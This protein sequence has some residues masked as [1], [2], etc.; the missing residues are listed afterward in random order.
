MILD[1]ITPALIGALT[2]VIAAYATSY[3]K[4]R[5]EISSGTLERRFEAYLKIWKQ[6]GLLPEWPR[7]EEVTYQDLKQLSE[8]FRDWYFE[9]GGMLLSH[10][11]RKKY[12]DLQKIA[13]KAYQNAENEKD[14]LRDA[15]YEQV[16]ASCSTLRS[17]L[18]EDLLSRRQTTLL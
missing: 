3:L 18:T 16:R 8:G 17:A 1:Q 4:F 5:Q 7:S 6:T 9:G 11:S 10:N 12:G 15:D 13:T 14:H 2:G